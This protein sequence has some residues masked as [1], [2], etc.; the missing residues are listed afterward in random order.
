MTPPSTQHGR[1]VESPPTAHITVTVSSDLL[2]KL[3]EEIEI[4]E[5]EVKDLKEEV[6]RLKAAPPPVATP[7][8]RS[9][10]TKYGTRNQIELRLPLTHEVH[11]PTRTI[12]HYM[13]L[14]VVLILE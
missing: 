14:M 5:S 10:Y 8:P 13:G 7:P 4:L 1:D 9:Q 6:A 12:V 2:L 11:Q 3:R